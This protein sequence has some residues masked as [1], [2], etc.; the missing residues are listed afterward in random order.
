LFWCA[1]YG[2]VPSVT[3]FEDFAQ[4]RG[5][6]AKGKAADYQLKREACLTWVNKSL[7]QPQTQQELEEKCKAMLKP[8]A[9]MAVRIWTRLSD[10]YVQNE[11]NLTWL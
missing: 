3:L 9:A 1:N 5:Q 2:Y 8:D 11:V 4:G 7:G 10:T 6:M